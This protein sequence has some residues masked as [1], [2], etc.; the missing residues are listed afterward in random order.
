[1]NAEIA[2]SSFTSRPVTLEERLK[3]VIRQRGIVSKKD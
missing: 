2:I 1:M 3:P